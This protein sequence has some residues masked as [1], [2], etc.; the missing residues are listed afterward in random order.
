M[1]TN[2]PLPNLLASGWPH[3]RLNLIITIIILVF[4]RINHML[5]PTLELMAHTSSYGTP[6]NNNEWLLPLQPVAHGTTAA[7]EAAGC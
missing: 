1:N 5:N 6:E 3:Q 2:H 7:A 4:F